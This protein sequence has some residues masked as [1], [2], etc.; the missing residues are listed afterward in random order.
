MLYFIREWVRINVGERDEQQEYMNLKYSLLHLVWLLISA[1]IACRRLSYMNA[2]VLTPRTDHIIH[3]L[4]PLFPKW[5]IS[6]VYFAVFE[7]SSP[8]SFLSLSI[9]SPL[10]SIME[11]RKKSKSVVFLSKTKTENGVFTSVSHVLSFSP[12]L[13]QAL[14]C[15]PLYTGTESKEREKGLTCGSQRVTLNSHWW[16]V[17]IRWFSWV[18]LL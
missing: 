12:F 7:I 2:S 6:E 8:F 16:K 10:S 13:H 5:K 1:Q 11:E 9:L 17:K 15:I 14:D 3:W 4:I 18:S